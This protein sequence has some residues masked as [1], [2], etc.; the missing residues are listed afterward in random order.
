MTGEGIIFGY[1]WLW[2][3]R[4]S[5]RTYGKKGWAPTLGVLM[6]ILALLLVFGIF[7]LVDAIY[8]TAVWWR[9]PFVLNRYL[10]GCFLTSPAFLV[11][12]IGREKIYKLIARSLDKVRRKQDGAFLA[13]LLNHAEIEPGDVYYYERADG[14]PNE[15]F[16]ES[17]PRYRF[18]AACVLDVTDFELL[19]ADLGDDPSTKIS[20]LSMK[21]I[22][23][24]VAQETKNSIEEQLS[25]FMVSEEENESALTSS[26]RAQKRWRRSFTAVKS[27]NALRRTGMG[28]RI[29]PSLRSARWI[30]RAGTGSLSRTKSTK[31]VCL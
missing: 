19:I 7:Y 11:V 16:A 28:D 21:A 29:H 4:C 8:E 2:Q 30:N 13:V 12:M 23:I 1:E 3:R 9:N 31:D 5:E 18:K 6:A 26:E 10:M 22:Q 27:L 25:T 24:L 15:I 14:Q 17:D 20:Q